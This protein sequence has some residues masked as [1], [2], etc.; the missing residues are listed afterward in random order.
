MTSDVPLCDLAVEV[1]EERVLVLFPVLNDHEEEVGARQG[2]HVVEARHAGPGHVARD[3]A[4][5]P[6]NRGNHA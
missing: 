6:C 5:R 2:R 3:H 1:V 4:T